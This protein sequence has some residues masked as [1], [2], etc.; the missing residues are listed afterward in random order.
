M[1]KFWYLKK[2]KKDYVGP[3]YRFQLKTCDKKHVDHILLN[4]LWQ[5]QFSKKKKKKKLKKLLV[6]PLELSSKVTQ[7][8]IHTRT[9][10]VVKPHK[11]HLA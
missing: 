8:N 3:Y 11:T 10:E 2:K 5:Q 1:L 6:V 4:L 7:K 9:R